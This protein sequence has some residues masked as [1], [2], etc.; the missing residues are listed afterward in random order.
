MD[1]LNNKK[2][3]LSQYA[4][5]A[6]LN[7]RISIHEKYSTNKLGFANWIFSNYKLNQGAKVLELGCGTGNMWQNRADI[8]TKCSELVLSDFSEGMI[9]TA[10]ENLKDFTEISYKKID[11]QAIPFEDEHF[12]IVIANMMLYHVPDIHKALSEVRRVLKKGGSFYAATYGE[13]GIME[14]LCK[15][16][17]AFGVTD[18]MNKNFTL[19]NGAEIL[20]KHFANVER[21]DYEDSLE[22]TNIDD[23][24]EYIYSLSSMT[25]LYQYSKDEIKHT[26]SKKQ[27]N[28]VLSIPKEYGIFV[29]C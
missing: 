29:C 3:V 8:I 22:I 19:Q 23:L 27:K 18:K 5:S 7:T 12:D 28:G 1:T 25:A 9:K 16:L 15:S 4:T 24:I 10:Q 2:A 13:H 26:L 6:N 21:L 20:K 17:H 11:I 14:Y